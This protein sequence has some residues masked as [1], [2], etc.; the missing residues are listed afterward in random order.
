MK[1]I[2]FHTLYQLYILCV[3]TQILYVY[4]QP[5]WDYKQRK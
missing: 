4:S 5:V 2:N 1:Q 3:L